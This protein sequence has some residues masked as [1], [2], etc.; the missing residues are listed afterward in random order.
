MRHSC[1]GDGARR[2]NV[3]KILCLTAVCLMVL[4][5]CL[6]GAGK[7]VSLGQGT[8]TGFRLV[9]YN[10][11]GNK[12]SFYTTPL[13]YRDRGSITVHSKGSARRKGAE[14]RTTLLR[15]DLASLPKGAPVASAKLVFPMIANAG[16]KNAVQVF[17]V[18]R[19][20]TDKVTWKTTD[21]NTPWESEGVHGAKDKKQVASFDMPGGKY[22]KKQPTEVTVDVTDLVKEW[23]SGKSVNNGIKLEMT[24]G[25]VRFAMK[26][27]R[28]Q[29]TTK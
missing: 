6:V 7:T 15:F 18:L 14:E 26:G 8:W 28:L 20:W 23:V 25:Y 3:K 19:P 17:R 16:K 12:K 4:S 11:Y 2:I 13:K 27:F 5:T 22:D 10:P 9:G 21:G 1:Y 24:G 29:I